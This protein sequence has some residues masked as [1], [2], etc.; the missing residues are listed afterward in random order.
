MERVTRIHSNKILLSEF[1]W[2]K[3]TRKIFA[4]DL[5]VQS[6][7]VFNINLA[8]KSFAPQFFIE[9]SGP[10]KDIPWVCLEKKKKK[11]DSEVDLV[12]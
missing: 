8:Y 1:P 6:F 9:V 2:R 12:I 10:V 4:A 3:W 5:F 11:K 7:E